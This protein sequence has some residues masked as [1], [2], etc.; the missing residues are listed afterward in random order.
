MRERL[1]RSTATL[2]RRAEAAMALESRLA[3]PE[4]YR[5]LLCRLLGLHR[6]LETAMP[7]IGWSGTGIDIPARRKCGWLEADLRDLGTGEAALAAIPSCPFLPRLESAAAGLGALYVSEGASLG[8]RIVLRQA[9]QRLGIDARH[10][11]RFFASYGPDTGPMWRAC[12]TALD[13]LD[14]RSPAADEAQAAAEA[15]FVAFET[16]LSMPRAS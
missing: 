11:G 4:S 3:S 16:W 10:G 13:T 15:M 9:S 1:R 7:R 8:G 6:P 2:H 14:C 5:L 12:V